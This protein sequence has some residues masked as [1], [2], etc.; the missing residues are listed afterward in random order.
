MKILYV[1][2]VMVLVGALIGG[3]TNSL[4]IRMLFR[5]YKPVFLFGK[6]V[7][8]TPGLIPKRRG[9]LADQLGKLVMEHLLTAD[10]MKRKLENSQFQEKMEEWV[11]AELQKYLESGITVEEFLSRFGIEDAEVLLKGNLVRIV[12]YKYEEIMT[13]LRTKPFEQVLPASMVHSV[14]SKIP[15][16]AEYVLTKAVHYFESPEGK[17]QLNKMI[18]DFIATRGKLGSVV[19]MFMGNYNIVDKVQPEVVKFL[20]HDGTKDVLLKVLYGEWEK[21]KGMEIREVEDKL[22]KETILSTI[23][24]ALERTLNIQGWM[25]KSIFEAVQPIHPWMMEKLVP[26]ILLTGSHLVLEKLE[27]LLAKLQLEDVVRDQVESFSLE[28]LEEMVL[29]VSKKELK[30]ITYLGALLGGLIGL[31]QGMFVLLV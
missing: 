2:S 26:S 22:T 16:A 3:V 18:Q 31:F 4:A 14:H 24:K 5:P 10:S 20:K 12:E 29:S 9:E 15:F 8:F 1:I 13:G 19:Q 6:R 25:E 30:M 28:Q 11:K 21:I 17:R 7:P 27:E 23:H